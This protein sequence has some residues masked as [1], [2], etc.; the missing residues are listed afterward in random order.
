MIFRDLGLVSYLTTYAAMQRFTA[1]RE[2]QTADEIWLC[3]HYPVYTQGRRG[4]TPPLHS[5]IPTIASNRGGLITYH[6][7]GQ[8]VAYLLLNIRRLG[9]GPRRLVT[10]IESAIIATL[11]SFNVPATSQPK[12]P[13]VYVDTAKIAALGLRIGNGC[14]YHGLSLNVDMDLTPFKAIAPCGY[15]QLAVTQLVDHAPDASLVKAQGVLKQQLVTHLI[16]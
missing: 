2:E 3:Q 9:L 8:Q 4:G 1:A 15:P 5:S 11:A 7:P 12:A 14:C 16:A 13:G 10:Q 6:G